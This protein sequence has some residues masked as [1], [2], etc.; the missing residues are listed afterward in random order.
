MTEKSDEWRS[1]IME[2]NLQRF[3]KS[4]SN[5]KL[6]IQKDGVDKTPIYDVLQILSATEA[7]S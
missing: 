7:R 4:L 5:D 3:E 1:C 6:I 2:K